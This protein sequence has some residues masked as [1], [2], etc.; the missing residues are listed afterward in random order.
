MI[1]AIHEI[2][3]TVHS[4]LIHKLSESGGPNHNGLMPVLQLYIS[5]YYCFWRG[6]YV[7]HSKINKFVK[8]YKFSLVKYDT[9]ILCLKYN[10]RLLALEM[11]LVLGAWR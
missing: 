5:G 7:F 6:I 8:C 11:L 2:V 1:L 9:N 10:N 4:F 3:V